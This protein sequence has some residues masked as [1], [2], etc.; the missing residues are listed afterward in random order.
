MNAI[1]TDYKFCLPIK[2]RQE[3]GMQWELE[4]ECFLLKDT[5]RDKA[6]SNKS[7][8]LTKSMNM[9]GWV[10]GASDQLF[11]RFFYWNFCTEHFQRNELS[12]GKTSLVV[13]SSFCT[14]HSICLNIGFW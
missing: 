13:I 7:P 5:H 2:F 4:Y 9:D 11:V 12:T 10:V 14:L 1:E 6:P 3:S 8:V